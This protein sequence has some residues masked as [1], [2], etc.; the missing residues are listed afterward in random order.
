MERVVFTALGEI[1]AASLP[2]I[3]AFGD[4]LASS[5]EKLIHH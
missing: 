1:T 2:N 5:S 3:C 4:Y